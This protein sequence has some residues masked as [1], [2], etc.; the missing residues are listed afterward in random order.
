MHKYR[1]L[2]CSLRRN[3]YNGKGPWKPTHYSAED[4]TKGC[5]RGTRRRCANDGE[6]EEGFW[7]NHGTT[8]S[9]LGVV[10]EDKSRYATE[11]EGTMREGKWSIQ[12]IAKI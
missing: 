1:N 3:K 8:E 9:C 10:I 6:S 2:I 7:H 5:C 12:H 4:L 11:G